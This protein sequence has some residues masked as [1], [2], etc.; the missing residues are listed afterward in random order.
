MG[1]KRKNSKPWIRPKSWT[2]I[3]ER[4]ELKSKS[5]NAKTQRIQ[6]QLRAKYRS[7]DK[8]VKKS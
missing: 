3:E 6:Q 2:K 8:E 7:K 1:R 4:K 5:E